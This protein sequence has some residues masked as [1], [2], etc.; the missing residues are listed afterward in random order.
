MTAKPAPRAIAGVAAALV[1]GLVIVVGAAGLMRTPSDD[2][3]APL[4]EATVVATLD[5]AGQTYS[6][7]LRAA[8]RVAR[9]AP[10]DAELA[11]R[12][13]RTL[14]AEGRA[15]GNSRLVGA[16]LGV[17]RPFLAPPDAEILTLA[18]NA[19]QYQHDFEGALSMLDQAIALAPRDTDA[20][21]MR[22]TINTVLGRFD[23]ADGDCRGLRA[24]DRPDLGFLCQSVARTLTAEAPAVYE[25][26]AAIVEQGAMLD[27][28]LRGYALGLMGEIAALQG[29]SD[30]ARAH[31]D[32]ALAEDPGDIR[33]RMMLADV[34]LD[35]D[36]PEAA[37][38]LLAPAPDVDGVVIRRAV[39]AE[40]SGEDAVAEAARTELDRRF[41]QN[42]DLGLTA[43]A[44]EETRFYLQVEPD[45][46]L[47]LER[48]R[49][50]WDLQREIEDAQLLIDASVA[51]N[52]PEA[53]EPVLRWMAAQSVSV[54]TL[55]IPDAV[56]EAAR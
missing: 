21:L 45:P 20:V 1:A 34:L 36:D 31:L 43:H 22:A 44:R 8:L 18:A 30:R 26:L 29:W 37:F 35:D 55:R 5:G 2:G 52:V 3:A 33:L 14:I 39:A 40:R 32:A 53:A 25:R 16:A 6:D 38:R 23:V 4:S 49:V 54:P 19:R 10:Q 27:L 48:A 51:A 17:L 7:D 47:A 46:A 24:L 12:A 15:A 11:K 28:A 50:N 9:A 41:R 13:A 42:I 56:R